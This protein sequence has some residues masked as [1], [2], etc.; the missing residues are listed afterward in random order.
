MMKQ[1]KFYTLL[2]EPLLHFLV[3]GAGLFFL[4]NQINEPKAGT[5]HRII[6]TQAD[7][8]RLASTWL[9]GMG[10]PPT[11]Q[12][13]EQQLKHYIHEQVLYREALAMG[14]DRD[15]VI[16]RRRLAKK[17]QYLFNDLS[18]IPDP[19]E[20]ELASF[21]SE[22]PEK[23]TEPASITF[24]QIFLDPKYRDQNINQDAEQLLKQLKATPAGV[25]AIDIGD[26]SLLPY[27]FSN[28]RQS[29]IASMFGTGYA[30]KVFELPVNSWQ[31]PVTSAYG[32]HLIYITSRT[33]ARLPPLAEIHR[34][35]V[36]AWRTLKQHEA[37]EV[38]YQSLYQRYEIILDDD[39]AKNVRLSTK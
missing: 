17:M 34:R 5:D 6:I 14:L 25:H 33:A 20:T 30:K 38:F 15:D 39:V 32:V 35:V 27:E 3:L 37:N 2:R 26:R 7:L 8:N 24:K 36:K 23:F 1:S 10:R 19:T 4:F 13:R 16:V 22:H 28:A 9:K 11:A 29:E 31:G 12:E 18:L 21:L